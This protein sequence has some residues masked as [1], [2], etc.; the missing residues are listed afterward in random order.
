MSIP[1]FVVDLQYPEGGSQKVKY[2]RRG[3]GLSFFFSGATSGKMAEG[4]ELMRFY[5][6][7]F[8][9]TSLAASPD[10]MKCIVR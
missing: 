7:A 10:I 1:F 6:L 2:K 8:F 4:G 3:G 5:L 9:L